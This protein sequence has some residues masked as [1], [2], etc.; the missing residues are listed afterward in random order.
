MAETIVLT[1]T[2]CG[3]DY[4]RRL[5]VIRRNKSKKPFCSREHKVAYDRRHY[6]DFWCTVDKSPGQGPKGDCWLWQGC[7]DGMG[8][9]S[10]EYKGR[11]FLAHRRAYELVKGSIPKGE[12]YHGTVVRH[13]CDTPRCCRPD[14]LILGTQ[15]DNGHD[16][17]S[18]GRVVSKLT[19]EKVVAIRADPR[20]YS[21][22]CKEYGLCLA[23]VSEIKRRLIW[24]HI[25]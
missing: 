9:G 17:A 25:P 8:Y 3:K 4:E 21:K 14:H 1:C 16:M 20:S 19:E 2:Y 18:R 5:S 24:K 7:I 22:I 6:E 10:I 12:G 11:V 23:T 13:T 15:A